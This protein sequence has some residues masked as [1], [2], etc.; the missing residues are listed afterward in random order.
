MP[1]TLNPNDGYM[2]L[3]NTFTVEPSK[4]DELLAELTHATEMRIRNR[5]GFISANLHVSDDRKHIANYAQ[6][7]TRADY[8]AFINDPEI[9]TISSN[10]RT[11]PRPSNRSSMSFV[12]R[13][14]GINRH[15]LLGPWSAATM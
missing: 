7:R 8:D 4:A 12:R 9:A 5:P 11:L 10:R 14:P 15:D 1:T 13:P 6:W 3:I 2:V